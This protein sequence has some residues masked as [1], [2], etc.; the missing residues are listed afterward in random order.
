MAGDLAVAHHR[1]AHRRA[2]TLPRYDG[3]LLFVGGLALICVVLAVAGSLHA[4]AQ[5]DTRDSQTGD[6]GPLP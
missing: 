2:R 1:A 3:A 6:E 4:A 5:P